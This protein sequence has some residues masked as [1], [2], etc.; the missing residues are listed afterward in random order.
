MIV[1]VDYGMG[2]LRSVFKAF[3]RINKEVVVSSKIE[4]IRRAD[5]LILPGVGYFKRGIENLRKLNLIEVLNKRVIGDKVP[6]LGICLGMQLL[7]EFSEG[8]VQRG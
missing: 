5:K 2:N 4:E 1:I 3:K 6:I 8:G 7:T